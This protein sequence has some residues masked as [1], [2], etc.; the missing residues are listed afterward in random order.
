LQFLTHPTLL[1]E[2]RD[3]LFRGRIFVLREKRVYGFEIS[4][5][6]LLE[7]RDGE[8]RERIFEP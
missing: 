4:A 5:R 7:R 8:A 6:R 1:G 2:L 3:S